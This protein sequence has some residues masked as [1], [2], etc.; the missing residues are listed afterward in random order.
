MQILEKMA[1]DFIVPPLDP[2]KHN[3]YWDSLTTA[4]RKHPKDINVIDFLS[5]FR[6][7]GGNYN[8]MSKEDIK[9]LLDSVNKAECSFAFK[10]YINFHKRILG[11]LKWGRTTWV[12]DLAS[13]FVALMGSHTM[14]LHHYH[15]F[16]RGGNIYV[17]IGD[18]TYDI[19]WTHTY[20][21]IPV[22]TEEYVTITGTKFCQEPH[23]LLTGADLLKFLNMYHMYTTVLPHLHS[24]IRLQRHFDQG[25]T[26]ES[27]DEIVYAGTTT[28]NNQ[29]GSYRLEM[30]KPWTSQQRDE[31]CKKIDCWDDD[32]Y[33][34][35]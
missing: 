29:W 19:K 6:S 33:D 15:H 25:G 4:A 7:K 1:M 8:K 31:Y 3:F 11:M 13:L 16:A 17:K 2:A 20:Y 12:S 14:T 34:R 22:R 18:K 32:Y 5:L 30:L 26:V 35:W 28:T 23:Q 10:D 9:E 27:W 24:P 21:G